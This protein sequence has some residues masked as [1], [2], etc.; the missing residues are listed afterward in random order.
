MFCVLTFVQKK[1]ITL[2][3]VLNVQNETTGSSRII[4]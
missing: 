3:N 1:Y 4:G 2:G